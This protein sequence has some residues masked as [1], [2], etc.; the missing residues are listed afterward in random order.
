MILILLSTVSL[1]SSGCPIWNSEFFSEFFPLHISFYMLL[2]SGYLR[3][4]EMQFFLCVF[5][6]HNVTVRWGRCVSP[7]MTCSS[8]QLSVAQW[9]E[10]PT[11]LWK[12]VSSSLHTYHSIYL[13]FNRPYSI[14]AIKA[15]VTVQKDQVNEETSR[16]ARIKSEMCVALE[17]CRQ[18]HKAGELDDDLQPLLRYMNVKFRAID[19][20]S[21]YRAIHII[22][23]CTLALR[24][25]GLWLAEI[26]RAIFLTN[27]ELIQSQACLAHTRFPALGTGLRLAAEV[28]RAT[29]SVNQ[30]WI[31]SQPCLA[32]TRFPVL[33][34]S[35]WLAELSRATFSTNQE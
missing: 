31:Q 1:I 27:H 35:Y 5:I 13:G 18:L 8:L 30:G 4:C 29:F 2:L 19:F 34:T 9:L 11:S 12:V 24:S 17:T 26:S 32:Y 33:G 23:T 21:L 22:S 6:W 10:R 3:D 7:Q 16:K 28:S 20:K 25:N 14:F 15:S